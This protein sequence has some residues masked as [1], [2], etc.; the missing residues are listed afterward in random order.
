MPL[1]GMAYTIDDSAYTKPGLISHKEGTL[2]TTVGTATFT[3]MKG[4][5]YITVD[6]TGP[7]SKDFHDSLLS[8]LTWP[9]AAIDDRRHRLARIQYEPALVDSLCRTLTTVVPGIPDTTGALRYGSIIL[10]R[11]KGSAGA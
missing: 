8:L 6:L 2:K 7:L 9:V 11:T 3:R 1:S 4:G 10:Y 5:N